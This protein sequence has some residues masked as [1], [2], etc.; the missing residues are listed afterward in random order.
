MSIYRFARYLRKKVKLPNVRFFAYS[1]P[2]AEVGDWLVYREG[3]Q[4]RVGRMFASLAGTGDSDGHIAVL[5]L[6]DCASHAHFRWVDPK[7]VIESEP[8]R[9]GRREFLQWFAGDWPR[10]FKPETIVKL[11]EYGTLCAD[12]IHGLET[13]ALA[14]ENDLGVSAV[15]MF[16]LEEAKRLS[17]K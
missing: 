12:H 17:G 2:V 13:A 6:D 14:F 9:A 3:D 4:F 15:R 5:T 8:H 10:R 11:V 16:G 7:D 1:R